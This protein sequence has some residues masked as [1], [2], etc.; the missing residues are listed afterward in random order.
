MQPTNMKGKLRMLSKQK[1]GN[2]LQ[3]KTN[4][5]IMNFHFLSG[6]LNKSLEINRKNA[7][8]EYALN[9]KET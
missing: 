9:L 4:V 3:N 2:G 7:F 6:F 5:E 1:L 8:K